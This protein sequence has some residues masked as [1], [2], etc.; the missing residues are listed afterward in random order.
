[1]ATCANVQCVLDYS[2]EHDR[3]LLTNAQLFFGDAS[4]DAVI[5]EP[6]EMIRKS[7]AFLVATTFYQSTTPPDE[8][9]CERFKTAQAMLTEA[10]GEFSVDLFRQILDATH[11]EGHYPTQYSNAYDLKAGIMYLYLFHDFE[12]V[13]EINLAEELALGTHEYNIPS[14]FP[15]NPEQVAFSDLSWRN[16]RV[17]LDGQ[18]YDPDIDTG[19]FESYA[20][21]YAFPASLLESGA[22]SAEYVEI[23]WRDGWLYYDLPG[24]VTMP[25]PLY[26]TSPTTFIAF[27]YDA[28][29]PLFKVDIMFD[30]DGQVSGIQGDFGNMALFLERIP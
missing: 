7:G 18:G 15:E 5:I 3:T 8:I 17:L 22:V 11:Q 1:M 19:S 30:A 14:L 21:R 16:Y 20:G 26:P 23:T 6:V 4:G 12:H 10:N 24:D 13:V 25:M 28:Y 9:I 29:A 2:N 27:S